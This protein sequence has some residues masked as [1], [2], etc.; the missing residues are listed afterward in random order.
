VAFWEEIRNALLGFAITTAAAGGMI[1]PLLFFAGSR[2]LLPMQRVRKGTWSGAVVLLALLPL[3]LSYSLA[4]TLFD[5]SGIYQAIFDATSEKEPFLR[6]VLWASPF[7]L[8]LFL[9]SLYSIMFVAAR[10][11][12]FQLGFSWARWPQNAFLGYVAFLIL[13]PL[14]LGLN[15]FVQWLFQWAFGVDR[16]FHPL[17]ELGKKSLMPAEWGLFFFHAA[18]T[19]AIMEELYFRGVFQGWL[20]HAPFLARITPKQRAF[21]AIFGSSLFWAAAHFRAWPD[22]IP[23]FFLGLGLGFLAYRTQNLLPGIVVHGLFNSV[24]VLELILPMFV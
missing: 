11:R 4:V 8:L 20:L 15:F 3:V 16:T 1:A 19:A 12:P 2:R 10:I 13:T 5:S 24:A 23:L 7:I 22:P 6:L 9:A 14:I 18:V 21:W 17:E